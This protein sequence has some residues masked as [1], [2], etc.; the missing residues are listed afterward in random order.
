MFCFCF[1]L[2]LFYRD[3]KKKKKIYKRRREE[4]EEKKVASLDR[5]PGSDLAQ[6]VSREFS[7]PFCL[8]FVVVVEHTHKVYFLIPPSLSSTSPKN[9]FCFSLAECVCVLINCCVQ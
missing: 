1:P 7:L 2:L 9:L 3:Q 6:I 5:V 4:E 8:M